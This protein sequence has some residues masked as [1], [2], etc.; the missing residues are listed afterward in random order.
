MSYGL[1]PLL[2]ESYIF[3]FENRKV[4]FASIIRLYKANKYIFINVSTVYI[5]IYMHTSRIAK[6]WPMWRPPI[7]RK[8][9]NK[10]QLQKI[11]IRTYRI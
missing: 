8:A 2:R 5:F 9:K 7:M 1:C 4:G 10:I 6:I 11:L 3:Y